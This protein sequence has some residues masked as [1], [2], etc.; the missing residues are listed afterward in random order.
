MS[1]E[2]GQQTV[3]SRLRISAADRK[4]SWTAGFSFGWPVYERYEV[5]DGVMREKGQVKRFIA[6]AAEPERILDSLLDVHRGKA[7]PEG[8]A[9][10]YGLLGHAHVVERAHRRGGDPVAWF[11][12][13]AKDAFDAVELSRAI[14]AKDEQAIKG[15]FKRWKR[16]F[17]SAK[18]P[19]DP[20]GAAREALT[21][22]VN[23]HLQGVP[24]QLQPYGD[25]LCSVFQPR[26]LVDF[27]FWTIADTAEGRL[28]VGRCKGCGSLFVSDDPRSQ[29]CPGRNCGANARMRKYRRGKAGA[30]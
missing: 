1:R 14:H 2:A 11:G 3:T 13:Q 16:L 6:P 29:Y 22:I 21:T 26:A 8:F 28:A 15:F 27:V 10:E 12:Q 23:P 7:S 17:W 18:M 30:K 20:V 25:R 5:K 4:R 19:S 24:R 9:L